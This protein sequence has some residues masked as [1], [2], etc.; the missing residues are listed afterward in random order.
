MR[1]PLKKIFGKQSENATMNTLSILNL[2]LVILL[3]VGV[4]KKDVINV[5]FICL[6]A[7]VII[8]LECPAGQVNAGRNKEKTP[9]PS[10][11]NCGTNLTVKLQKGKQVNR[12]PKKDPN[13]PL[14]IDQFI[15]GCQAN[16]ARHVNIIGDY[17]ETLKDM[18]LLNG[19]YTTRGEWSQFLKKNLKAAKDMVPF[20]DD[21]IIISMLEIEK[22]LRVNGGY[23]DKFT[24]RTVYN[25]MV[26]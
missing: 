14:L 5:T 1:K 11:P 15:Q 7:A 16:N 19:E 26:K 6:I 2:F 23:M 13:E 8:M 25:T 12:R 21:L 3:I 24:L 22:S 20:K 18:K 17:A 4:K 9:M 10:C